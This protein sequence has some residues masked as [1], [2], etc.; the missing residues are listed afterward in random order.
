[1][2]AIFAATTYGSAQPQEVCNN[3]MRIV[4]RSDSTQVSEGILLW[5][6]LFTANQIIKTTL[7]Y[8]PDVQLVAKLGDSLVLNRSMDIYYPT[9]TLLIL[10]EL[11]NPVNKLPVLFIAPQFSGLREAAANHAIAYS[12]LGYITVVFSY[13]SDFSGYQDS[14]AFLYCADIPTITYLGAQDMRAAI[15]TFTRAVEDAKNLTSNELT[16]KY[17]QAPASLRSRLKNLRADM[18]SYFA[19]G[20][21]FGSTVVL[22][23]LLRNNETDWPSYLYTDSVMLVDGIFGEKAYGNYGPLDGVGMG[24]I[25]NE[26]FPWERIKGVFCNNASSFELSGLNFDDH[27]NTFPIGFMHG[28]CDAHLFYDVDSIVNKNGSCYPLYLNVKTGEWITAFTNY[29]SYPISQQLNQLGA[30]SEMYTFCGAGHDSGALWPVLK[31]QIGYGFFKR[32]YCEGIQESFTQA[33]KLSLENFSAQCCKNSIPQP[34]S[35]NCDCAGPNP[36]IE[37]GVYKNSSSGTLYCPVDFYCPT[38]TN[39]LNISTNERDL[40]VNVYFGRESFNLE[41]Q[42]PESGRDIFMACDVLGRVL[43]QRPIEYPQGKS[44]VVIAVPE[45]YKGILMYR[46]GTVSGK[47]LPQ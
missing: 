5:D 34:Y 18:Q 27:P 14:S 16:D 3:S 47:V 28:T 1:M 2:F 30:A 10:D 4:H 11:N 6:T 33:Y 38:E 15:R 25:R 20:F 9:N 36:P 31:S 23:A 39:F 8:A 32:A 35:E 41:I 22:N 44:S 40:D 43:I 26:P 46:I 37:L 7:K 12:Q 42:A 17:G 45:R 24:F 13:R 29:G 19:T 21:S